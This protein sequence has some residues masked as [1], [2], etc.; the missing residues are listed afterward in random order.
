MASR[1]TKIYNG[2]TALKTDI[3]NWKKPTKDLSVS[4]EADFR[5]F[6]RGV[7]KVKHSRQNGKVHSKA[8][9]AQWNEGRSLRTPRRSPSLF[10]ET[11]P[12]IPMGHHG[13]PL[14]RRT[15]SD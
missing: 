15:P 3:V 1:T 13:S 2:K 4:F 11:T 7:L 8:A 12:S 6:L 14:R 10:A 9:A 5:Q